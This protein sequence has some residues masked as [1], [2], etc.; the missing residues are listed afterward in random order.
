MKIPTAR[1]RA[2]LAELLEALDEAER[3]RPPG[4]DYL[5]VTPE[6]E[7]ALASLWSLLL[8]YSWKPTQETP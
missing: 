8:V 2:N 5:H 3:D 7:A 1:D 4:Q 6:L